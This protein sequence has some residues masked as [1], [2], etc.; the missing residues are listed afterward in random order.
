ML[1]VTLCDRCV[2]TVMQ[3]GLYARQQ[4]QEFQRKTLVCW[5]ATLS[6]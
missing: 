4:N 5:T 2:W 6:L 3:A 1:I